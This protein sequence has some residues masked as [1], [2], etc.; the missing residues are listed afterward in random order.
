MS[1]IRYTVKEIASKEGVSAMLVY[2]WIK[3]GYLVAYRYP[4]KKGQGRY[5]I[6]EDDYNNFKELFKKNV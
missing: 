2:E 4:S 1:E 6:T 5:V 3:L